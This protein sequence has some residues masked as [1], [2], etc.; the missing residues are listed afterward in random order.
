MAYIRC[1]CKVGDIPHEGNAVHKRQHRRCTRA[2]T[3]RIRRVIDTR[4]RAILSPQW[5]VYC[6]PCALAISAH[7]GTEV[8][9]QLLVPVCE[10]FALCKNPA[11]G[12]TPH[13]VLGNVPTCDDCHHSLQRDKM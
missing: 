10:W 4:G 9:M 11:T 8:E 3:R 1:E 5:Y 13:P 6:E 2:A 12:T 7:Q